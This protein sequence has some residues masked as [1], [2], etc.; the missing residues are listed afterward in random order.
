MAVIER[1][2][3]LVEEAPCCKLHSIT[4]EFEIQVGISINVYHSRIFAGH[5]DF[6]SNV[7]VQQFAVPFTQLSAHGNG[8]FIK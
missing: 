7:I 3:F 8:V 4:E 6:S 5:A 1:R 2:R